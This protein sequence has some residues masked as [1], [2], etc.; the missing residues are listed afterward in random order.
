[1]KGLVPIA[2][3]QGTREDLQEV[4][5]VGSLAE[6]GV[7]VVVPRQEAYAGVSIDY[8]S[9]QENVYHY[10]RVPRHSA[11]M[12]LDK[13]ERSMY[14]QVGKPPIF[15]RPHYRRA[16]TLNSKTLSIDQSSI[17]GR[18]TVG[19][20][21][22]DKTLAVA[23]GLQMALAESANIDVPTSIPSGS[24]TQVEGFSPIGLNDL[25]TR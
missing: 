2:D 16:F 12:A 7:G 25:Y 4:Q 14:E 18:G 24:L 23:R 15:G 21:M 22:Y 8:P 19:K 3:S 6:D 13:P 5:G 10:I 9:D 1:M 20:R 11:A 17:D